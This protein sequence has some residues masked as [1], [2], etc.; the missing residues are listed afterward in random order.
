MAD[1]ENDTHHRFSAE[2]DSF[3]RKSTVGKFVYMF[4]EMIVGVNLVNQTDA[5]TKLHPICGNCGHF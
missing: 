3:I 5:D 4:L 1:T 2:I